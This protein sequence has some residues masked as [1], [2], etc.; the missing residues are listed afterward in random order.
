[1]KRAFATTAL[2]VA[3]SVSTHVHAQS[4]NTTELDPILISGGI[5]PISA[6]EYG[7]SSTVITRQQIEDRGYSTVQE[8]LE[9]QPGVSI[10]GSAPTDRQ[11]RIRGGE[12]RHTLVLIDG[13]RAAAGDSEY[14]L[15]GLD[16]SYIERIEVL[17]G[18]QS[19]PF[20]T[21]AASGVINIVT[22]EAGEGLRYGG[23]VEF[24]EGDRQNAY[25]SHGG[26]ASR[27][28]VNLSNLN[29]RGF[30]YSGSDG[31][32][33]GR[34]WEAASAK[35]ELDL[36]GQTTL[37]FSLRAADAVYDFDGTDTDADSA[38]GY[39]VD[40]DNR[41]DLNERAGSIYLDHNAAGG[42][43]SHRLRFDRTTQKAFTNFRTEVVNYRLQTALDGATTTSSDQLLSV[44]LERREDRD[45]DGEGERDNNSAALEYRAWMTDS[46]SLQAGVR[47]DNNSEFANETTWNVAG[48][49]FLDNGVRWHASAGRA[50][51]NPS[52]VN[53]TGGFGVE[54]NPDLE[55]EKNIG[56]DVGVEIPLASDGSFVDITYFNETL[57]DKIAP[58]PE[59]F[60]LDGDSDR[61][62]VELTVF[63]KPVDDVDVTLNYTYTD[64][65]D[66]DG[67]I[68]TRRPRNE[69][70]LNA[71]WRLPDGATT[72]SGDLRY[73]R[74]LFD[75]QRWEDGNPI[76]QLPNFTVVNLAASHALT[77]NV[78]LTTRVTNVFDE[79][80][81]EVW[82]Y[83][84]RGRAVFAGLRASW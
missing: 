37:G 11:I 33:D 58:F 32:R 40:Q 82:G 8:A 63:L 74:G 41:T 67:N 76:E 70:G 28:S 14:V 21:D 49:Y 26:D 7:R 38:A 24:G 19:V 75:Q 10:N 5:S 36:T 17:R 45:R 62:G 47:R 16:A 27:I 39:V 79:D 46:A 29:D 60:N 30:D 13:V 1:M 77:D 53:I 68:E 35:G 20:G 73:V 65:N 81:Q 57:E 59:N 9:A 80:Y 66:P 84:T 12:G 18:P 69:V 6:D 23:S 61:Q 71:T 50:V 15:R 52:F 83:A 78:D 64:A 42:R 4:T 44:L 51:V 43:V 48:S 54:P 31:D 56:F 2:A 25:L 34:R 3:A 72:L 22:R 55:P